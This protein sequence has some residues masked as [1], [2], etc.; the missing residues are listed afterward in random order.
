MGGYLFITALGIQILSP[1]DGTFSNI[2]Y[3][4]P[5]G[6]P[7]SQ[8]SVSKWRLEDYNSVFSAKPPKSKNTTRSCFDPK[9]H[10]SPWKKFSLYTSFC[11]FFSGFHSVLATEGFFIS[12]PIDSKTGPWPA[13]HSYKHEFDDSPTFLPLGSK[14][15]VVR[16]MEYFRLKT[17]VLESDSPK[18]KD[19]FCH[20]LS[21]LG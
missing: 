11:G 8:Y 9:S 14:P 4:C 5:Q 21:S 10:S 12:K 1:G 19:W 13:I 18:F 17:W 15:N 20:L 2:S 7:I 16:G 6:H 3:F